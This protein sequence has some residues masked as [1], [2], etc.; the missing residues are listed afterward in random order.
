MDTLALALA[1]EKQATQA[2]D[3]QKKAVELAPQDLALRLNLAK[4]AQQAGDKA[5]ARKELVALQA[6]GTT[7]ALRDEAQKLLR[8]L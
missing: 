6:T 8:A 4:I 7:P 2:L 5:L 1:A 3:V